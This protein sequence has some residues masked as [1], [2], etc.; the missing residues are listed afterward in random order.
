MGYQIFKIRSL[1]FVL[2]CA[3]VLTGCLP[4]KG[5]LSDS[6]GEPVGEGVSTQQQEEDLKKDSYSG[7]LEKMMGLGIPLKCTW[8]MN[9]DYYGTNWIKG[10]KYYG[11]IVQKGKTAKLISKDDCIWAWEEG[12]P[13]GTKMCMQANQEEMKQAVDENKDMIEQQGYQPPDMDY[14][15]MP[16]IFGDD[17][18][19]PPGNISF[20]D[21]N[22]MVERMGENL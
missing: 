1:L 8:E 21:L 20:V 4:K 15:C 11:E 22:E 5:E 18:F 10:R 9:K 19:S 14:K 13:Q 3:L 7:N 12:N 17:K 2:F 16:A 6:K